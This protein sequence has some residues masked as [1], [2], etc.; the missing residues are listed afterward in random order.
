MVYQLNDL[1]S[2]EEYLSQ[3]SKNATRQRDVLL[4]LKEINGNLSATEIIQKTNSSYATLR[5]LENKGWILK[6]EERVERVPEIVVFKEKPVLALTNDQENALKVIKE[7]L[8]GAKRPI[9]LDGVTGSGKTEIYLRAIA[10]VIKQNKQ[11]TSWCQRY[12]TSQIVID[13]LI[14][15]VIR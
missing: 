11:A 8:N 15:L 1:D 13:L 4:L 9:L 14:D 5:A 3:L 6:K 12:F 7:E 10:D 2:I